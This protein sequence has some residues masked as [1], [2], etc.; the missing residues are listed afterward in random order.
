M[1]AVF[2]EVWFNGF[3]DSWTADVS[4]IEQARD[5]AKRTLRGKLARKVLYSVDEGRGAIPAILSVER[6]RKPKRK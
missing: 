6:K 3:S 4:S 2:T 1:K 5:M